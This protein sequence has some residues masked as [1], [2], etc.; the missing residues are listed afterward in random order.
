MAVLLAGQGN[1]KLCFIYLY[2][3]CRASRGFL[4]FLYCVSSVLVTG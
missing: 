2:S 4:G 1:S 3:Q